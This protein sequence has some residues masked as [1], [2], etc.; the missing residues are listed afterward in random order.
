MKRKCL[1]FIIS[2]FFR[3]FAKVVEIIAKY[4][5]HLDLSI[6][7]FGLFAVQGIKIKLKGQRTLVSQ[8][9]ALCRF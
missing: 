2:V 4:I 9:V 5:V 8:T 6:D 7:K 1:F 3:F